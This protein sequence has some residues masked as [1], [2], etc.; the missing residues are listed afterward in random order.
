MAI[1]AVGDIHG[2]AQP[3]W[4]LLDALDFSPSR[5]RLW[6][7]GDA[8]NRGAESL[9]VLRWLHAHEGCVTLVL[10]NHDLHLLA[11]AAGAAG[12]RK[13]D[14]LEEILAAPDSAILIDWLRRQPLAHWENDWLMVHAGALPAWTAA[15]T[16][17]YAAEVQAVLSS[18]DDGGDGGG[19]DNDSGG[20]WRAFMCE[21]YGDKPDRWD[22]GL[23]GAA[24][25]RVIVNA[26][27]RLRICTPQGVMNMAFSGAV[28]N[29]PPGYLPWFQA[30]ARRTANTRMVFGHW[31][32]LGLLRQ[33][34][35]CAI[36]SGCLWGGKLTALNLTSGEVVQSAG[37]AAGR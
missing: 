2:C 35:I 26:L 3:F 25:W 31:S 5:D 30:P 6:C 16:V 19:G 7:V 34:N 17:N 11:R 32:A 10:G 37:E 24:R 36:D 18:D 15:D 21:L 23:S 29:I 22:S 33:D 27:T 28:E 4:R 8:V 20:G 13:G 9:A 14:T 12:A 1:Y